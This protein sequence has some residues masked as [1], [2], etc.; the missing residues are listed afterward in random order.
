MKKKILFIIHELTMGGAE[1][2]LVNLINNIDRD[3]FEIHLAIFNN[4]GEL[5]NDLKED[6][7]VHDLKSK[8]VRKGIFKLYKLI[9]KL[10]PDI[11]FSGIAHVNL[12]LAVLIPFLS[13]KIK[14]IARETNTVSE[15]IKNYKYKVLIKILYKIFYK[16]YDLI[17][18][19]SNFMKNDLIK[20]FSILEN[21]LVVINNPLD[22][23]KINRMKKD[24]ISCIFEK[25][26]INLLAVGGL[27]YQKGFDLLL[28]SFSL[29]D[30]NFHLFIIGEGKE[31]TNLKKLAK[32]LKIENRVHFLGFQFNPYKFMSKADL[33][34]ISSR[35]EGFPNVVLEANA[36]GLPVVAFDCPGGTK[37]IIKN[38][39][40]G[41]LV[42][43]GDI[44]ALAKAIEKAVEYEWNTHEI[45]KNVFKKYNLKTK[46][47]EYEKYF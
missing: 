19:Q 18:S 41:F 24:Y 27:R 42:K 15:E 1:R 30:K 20:N 45:I 31:K 17:I 36:C 46:I 5:K 3:K 22:V 12:M 44:N 25:R 4:E 32:E 8:K 14:F 11:I 21:K 43:C 40:N 26:K 34:V 13:K 39:K 10:K 37:E 38:G 33:L 23:D 16:N 29:L 47:N 2:V 6:I 28:K 7:I 9:K 35:Y